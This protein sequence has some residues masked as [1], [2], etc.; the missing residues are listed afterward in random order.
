[1][2]LFNKD[3]FKKKKKKACSLEIPKTFICTDEYVGLETDL[4]QLRDVWQMFTT[5][6]HVRARARMA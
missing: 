6:T 2:K 5:H 1:M 4:K 3:R